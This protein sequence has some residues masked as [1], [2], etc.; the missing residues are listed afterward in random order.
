MKLFLVNLLLIL[1]SEVRACCLLLENW[2]NVLLLVVECWLLLLE[3]WKNYVF[4]I[5]YWCFGRGTL[6]FLAEFFKVVMRYLHSEP[7]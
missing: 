2:K 4:L 3:C 1:V 7:Y 5:Q 6:W